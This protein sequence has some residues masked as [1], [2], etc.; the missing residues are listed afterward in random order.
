[1]SYFKWVL[2]SSALHYISPDSSSFA[3]VFFSSCILGM[4]NDNTYI[5]LTGIG[6]VVIPHLSLSFMVILFQNSY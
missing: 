2:N 6:F 4:T 5:S 1:M 3:Y